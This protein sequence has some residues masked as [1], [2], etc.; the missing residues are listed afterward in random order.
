VDDDGLGYLFYLHISIK[1]N[2]QFVYCCSLLGVDVT[3]T[4][5]S[6]PIKKRLLFPLAMFD[7]SVLL[8]WVSAVTKARTRLY[9]LAAPFVFLHCDNFLLNLRTPGLHFE[10]I[11]HLVMI[12][13]SRLL[14]LNCKE[15]KGKKNEWYL[16][17]L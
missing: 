6:Y 1:K 7:N 13:L 14:P 2:H 12:L 9:N 8:L 11:Y 15:F 17:Y 3:S 16:R 4:F 5:D 10:T